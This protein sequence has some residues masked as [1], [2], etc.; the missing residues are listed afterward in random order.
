MKHRYFITIVLCSFI[1]CLAMLPA[2]A[3]TINA[4]SC[5]ASDVQTAM[6]AASASDIVAI[7]AGTC[8][9]TTSVIWTA[10]ANMTVLGAGTAATGGGDQTVITDNYAVNSPLLN[11]SVAATGTFRMSGITFQGGSGALKDNGVV[12]I[13]G[14]GIVRLDHLHFSTTTTN[15][16]KLL[17]I[18]DRVYGVLDHSILDL[19]SV[20][21]IYLYNFGVDGQGNTPFAEDTNFGASTFFFVEDN[22]INGTPATHDTRV[23]DCLVAGRV[24]VRFNTVTA[25][26]LGE[27]HATGSSSDVRGCRAV[28]I[29]GNSSAPGVGQT[30]PNFVHVDISNGAALFWGNV[31]A[32]DSYVHI[33]HFNVTRK[34][35]DTYNQQATPTGWGYCG[36]AFNGTGSNWDQNTSASTGYACVDQPGRGRSDLITGS[37]PNKVNSTTGTIAWPNQALEPIYIWANVAT[38]AAGWGGSWYNNN[39]GGRVVT[40]QDYYAQASGIQTSSSSP[41]N[42][43]TGTGWGTLANRPTTCTAGVGYFA[44]DQGSWNTSST[45]PYG[46]QQNGADGVLYKCTATNTWTLYYTPYTYPH[47]LTQVVGGTPTVETFT[48]AGT[49]TNGWTAHAGVTSVTAE[50]WG[51]GGAGGQRTTNGGGGGGAGGDYTKKV[52]TVTPG[53]AYTY[54]VG[55]AGVTGNPGTHGGFSRFTGDSAVK[56][57]AR[58][59]S[60]VA[61]NVTTGGTPGATG[62]NDGT[63]TFVGGSGANSAGGN[64]G[65]GGASAGTASTGTTATTATG[66][67]AVTGGGPGGNGATANNTNGFAPTSGPGGAG[68]GAKKSSGGATRNGGVGRAGQVRVSYLAAPSIPTGLGAVAGND[69]VTLDWSDV[70]GIT[71][72]SVYRGTA[73]GGETLYATG[74]ASSAYTDNAVDNNITYYYKVTALNGAAESGLS[75]EVSATPSAPVVSLSVSSLTFPSQDVDSTSAAQT[76]T[77]TNTGG[78]ILNITSITK[79]GTHPTNYAF[80][81]CGNGGATTVAPSANCIL[82]VTFT[83]SATGTRTANISIADDAAGSPHIITLSGTGGGPPPVT[84]S[85]SASFRSILPGQNT[86]LSYTTTEANT[87]CTIDQGIGALT[88]CSSGTQVV[89]PTVTTTYTLTAVGTTGSAQ[90][91]VTIVPTRPAFGNAGGQATARP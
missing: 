84:A 21:A 67:T 39:T 11:I 7:P 77:L 54:I 27:D 68:G 31:A 58:G 63:T 4:A 55:A 89:S 46:V 38:P 23:F 50:S 70:S 60:T 37:F 85:L 17:N 24:V 44:T 75:S 33:V 20:N 25:T 66:A 62:T 13:N 91:S 57:E 82:S 1:L 8:S 49:F 22:I 3:A 81:G 6:N 41:F 61:L 34:N 83:P 26:V 43:T 72:Y 64:G 78:L 48:T 90:A 47:P 42:G 36:T 12:K 28:E 59:G 32:T 56:V 45:N 86:T 15:T 69:V 88:P 40:D 16:A 10:P 18:V 5:N 73:S 9:W 35:N 29:Y 52:I 65:G 76:V 79:T 19:Y 2:S 74:V 53:N 87:S 30:Q 80:T 14:P 51:A 71:S